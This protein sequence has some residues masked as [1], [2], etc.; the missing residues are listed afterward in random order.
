MLPS[1]R[2]S[3]RKAAAPTAMKAASLPICD[4]GT[5]PMNIIR[6][7]TAKSRA[8]VDRFSIP[9]R[10]VVGTRMSRIYLNAL[11]SAPVSRCMALRIWAV[12]STIVPLAISDGWK[13][14]PISEMTRLAPLM[15]SPPM[16]THSSV[17]AVMTSRK[18]VISLK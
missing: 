13:V 11:R 7:M 6:K 2:I 16:S 4:I 3:T 18:G 12:T 10:N 9:I 5:W 1:V 17:I 14:K 8:A 15:L